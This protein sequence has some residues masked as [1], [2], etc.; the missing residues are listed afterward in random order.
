M[1]WLY[2]AALA[3]LI[4]VTGPLIVHLLRRQRATALVVPTVRFVPRIDQ[5]VVRLR[6]PADAWLLLLRM[7]IIAGA[8]LA[9]ARP[10]FLTDARAAAWQNRIARVVV[11]DRTESASVGEEAIAAAI[12]GAAFSHRIDATDVAAA[13][14]RARSW[15]EVSPPARREIVILSDFQRGTLATHDVDAVPPAIGLRFVSSAGAG[16]EASREFGA[17][18]VL[19]AEA[20]LQPQVQIGDTTTAVTYRRDAIELGGLRLLT[21][22]EDS[23]AA[24]ALGRIVSRAGA[25]APDA[26]QPVV[27]RFPGGPP[28][29][30][31]SPSPPAWLVQTALRL[32]QAAE[33]SALPLAVAA[34]AEA[35]LVD[36]AA[37]PR[38]LTA[39][40]AVK[41]ALDARRDPDAFREQ[42]VGV[43]PAETLQ[44]WTRAPAPA[45]TAAWQQSDESDARW[46]WL[47]VL[48]LLGVETV[49]RRTAPV[50]VQEDARAA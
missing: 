22:P 3:G 20:W 8:V 28:L 41:A 14:R 17:P 6:R 36:V 44:A 4:A 10:L 15:L 43:I 29:P 49:V 33:T 38:T 45:D 24:A 9:L 11:V 23:D 34:G 40:A 46:F 31:A 19:S 26:S 18:P 32:L 25:H 5:S 50:A 42:E 7:A 48:L 12:Q 37:A 21:A 47:G 30:P 39:A 16:A 27:V 35:L 13:L 1:V 2:P